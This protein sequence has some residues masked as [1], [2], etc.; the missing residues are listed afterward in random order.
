MNGVVIFDDERTVGIDV[1]TNLNIKKK[2][3]PDEAEPFFISP[4]ANPQK[5]PLRK[6]KYRKQTLLRV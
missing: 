1:I 3:L 2:V 5:E 4:S 6:Q